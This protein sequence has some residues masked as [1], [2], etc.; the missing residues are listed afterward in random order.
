MKNKLSLIVLCLALLQISTLG[1]SQN[2]ELVK[3]F[4]EFPDS[5]FKLKENGMSHCFTKDVRAFVL[6]EKYFNSEKNK[7]LV[8]GDVVS[9]EL[10]DVEIPEYE[11]VLYEIRID[12]SLDHIECEH[13]D[14]DLIV[15]LDFIVIVEGDTYKVMLLE[16]YYPGMCNRLYRY[17]SEYTFDK[18][19]GNY[20]DNHVS[21]PSFKWTDFYSRRSVK[22]INKDYLELVELP[23]YTYLS[24]VEGELCVEIMPDLPS[25]TN[26]F[27]GSMDHEFES[28]QNYGE[29]YELT[30]RALGFE[31]LP[32]AKVL[33]F[34]V[35][36]FA[37]RKK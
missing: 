15:S 24:E 5:L 3:V 25:L 7:Y 19:T 2:V 18:N 32:E 28:V 27:V 14:A 37:K 21:L 34:P 31:D 30:F 1:S 16:Q 22:V 26:L 12:E 9:R 23:Y 4:K 36:K 8:S 10:Q 29:D 17:L 11:Q 6:N 13:S 33:C 20:V 35:N